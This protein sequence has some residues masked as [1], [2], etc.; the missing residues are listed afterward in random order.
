MIEFQSQ[1]LFSAQV[2]ANAFVFRP[3][4]KGVIYFSVFIVASLV[5]LFFFN[6]LQCW[7]GDKNA[8]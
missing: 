5:I 4:L 7:I 8:E 3:W 6:G 2:F 1:N